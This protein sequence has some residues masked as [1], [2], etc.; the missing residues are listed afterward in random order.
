M[1]NLK[2]TKREAAS[3]TTTDG[4]VIILVE[5]SL[6]ENIGMTA[7]AMMNFGLTD[8]RLVRPKCKWPHSKAINASSG[9]HAVLTN[10]QIFDT[11]K[12]AV[13]DL[14]RLGA[15]TARLRDMIK[16][17]QDAR[18][19]AKTM[20]DTISEGNKCGLLFGAERVGLHNDDLALADTLITV[21]TNPAFSSLNLA[22][23]VLLMGYEW[24]MAGGVEV[25]S[26]IRRKGR[27]AALASQEE[28]IDFYEHLEDEM[29]KAGFLRVKEKRPRMIRNIRNIFN[30]ALL[31]EQEVRTLRGIVVAIAEKKWR[32]EEE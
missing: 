22:Q 20:R 18:S 13:A 32:R 5:T 6:A 21:P 8:L 7:R 24:Q 12:E 1:A 26:E 27:G 2:P 29:D 11:T 28:I 3:E 4:P 30:R 23:S 9:A 31:T 10:A 15:T 17:V 19:W 25:P 16:P 14:H